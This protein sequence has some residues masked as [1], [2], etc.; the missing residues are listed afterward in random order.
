MV[1]GTTLF[2][3]YCLN[4]LHTS[5]KIVNAYKTAHWVFYDIIITG[6][7]VHMDEV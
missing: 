5:A 6:H 2:T 4:M 7:D 3:G 1:E